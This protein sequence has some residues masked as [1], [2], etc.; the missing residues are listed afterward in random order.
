MKFYITDIVSNNRFIWWN[1]TLSFI[2]GK[3]HK[4][5]T[6]VIKWSDLIE[7]NRKKIQVFLNSVIR[8]NDALGPVSNFVSYKVSDMS[9]NRTGYKCR[10]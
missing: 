2:D 5:F 6:N 1:R 10:G 3:F 4:S 8:G 7:D 9:L